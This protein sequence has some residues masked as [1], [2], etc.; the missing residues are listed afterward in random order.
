M[1]DSYERPIHPI[2][3]LETIVIDN[4]NSNNAAEILSKT[5]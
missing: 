4:N 1:I 5:F 2:K 3:I